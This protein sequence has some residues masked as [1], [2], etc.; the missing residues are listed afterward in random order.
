[1]LF[2]VTA[3]WG[4][5]KP[6]SSYYNKLRKLGIDALFN[7]I[8]RVKSLS[9]AM[10]IAAM[11]Q[12]NGGDALV[13]P[14]HA[15]LPVL[16]HRVEPLET[17]F[18]GTGRWVVTCYECVKSYAYSGQTPRQCPVCGGL[19]FHC[20]PGY[21]RPVAATAGTTMF[22]QW[23]QTRFVTGYFEIPD[24][25]SYTQNLIPVPEIPPEWR[26]AVDEIR[27]FGIT[28]FTSLRQLD[29]ALSLLM[30]PP[31][32]YALGNDLLKSSKLLAGEEE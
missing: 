18:T 10:E 19:A 24:R 25:V 29:A 1:M 8:I 28:S 22:D 7:R 31:L 16:R 14:A 17:V 32:L 27:E 15:L 26:D 5:K 13:I 21:K 9:L 23:V 12:G 11:I 2:I 4:G 3:E 30:Y 6:P 20:R